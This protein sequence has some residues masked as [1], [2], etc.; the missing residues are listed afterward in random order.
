LCNKSKAGDEKENVTKAEYILFHA[1]HIAVVASD[2]VK[3]ACPAISIAKWTTRDRYQRGT[4]SSAPA[5]VSKNA[6][7]GCSLQQLVS[8]VKMF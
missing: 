2:M 4:Y 5:K 3:S 7:T 8:M 1:F 6:L